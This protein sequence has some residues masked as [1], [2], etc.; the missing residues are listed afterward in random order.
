MGEPERFA[1]YYLKF[2]EHEIVPNLTKCS[3]FRTVGSY[4]AGFS[5]I[6]FNLKA[7]RS[8]AEAA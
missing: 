3:T 1:L 4:C 6:E 5:C 7:A 2:M 8:F